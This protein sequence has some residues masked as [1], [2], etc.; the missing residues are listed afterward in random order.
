MNKF[1]IRPMIGKNKMQLEDKEEVVTSLLR[2]YIRVHH[3]E[4][5]VKK[6]LWGRFRRHNRSK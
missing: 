6:I 1:N 2:D 3:V 5:T 4:V